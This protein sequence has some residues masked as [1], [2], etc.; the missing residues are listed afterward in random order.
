MDLDTESA[1]VIGNT[2]EEN[3]RAGL[4]KTCLENCLLT[5]WASLP[6]SG[7][8]WRWVSKPPGVNICITFRRACL[9]S[10]EDS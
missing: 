2:V 3:T 6:L 7:G 9:I 4:L 5:F 1:T 10:G 8:G